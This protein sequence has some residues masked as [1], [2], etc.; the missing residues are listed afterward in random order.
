MDVF[1]LALKKETTRKIRSIQAL[2]KDN[3]RRIYLIAL[4]LAEA[5]AR[6]KTFITGYQ[7]RDEQEEIR[8]F[9]VVKP[10]LVSDLIYHCQIYNIELNRPV[11]GVNVVRGYLNRELKNIQDYKERHRE[12]YS[13]YRMGLTHSDTLFFTRGSFTMEHIFLDPSSCERD[14]GYSASCDYKLSKLMA[15]RKLEEYLL[16]QLALLERPLKT[17]KRL[18]W[19]MKKRYL[20]ELLYAMDS[21]HVFGKVPL[22]EVVDISEEEMGIKLGNVSSTFAEM[23][24]RDEATPFLDSL[25]EAILKRMNREKDIKNKK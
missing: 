21:L 12:F 17:R 20:V 3:L 5:N 9:K 22:R 6:L 13:Y 16:L 23:R 14:S 7:F 2:E 19:M 25:K 4:T 8:F 15:N 1:S 18:T 24:T 10:E 11:G